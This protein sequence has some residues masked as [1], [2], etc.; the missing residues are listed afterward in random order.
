[1]VRGRERMYSLDAARLHVIAG[2]WLER[3]G[4]TG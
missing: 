4:D 3:F 2:S 1:V